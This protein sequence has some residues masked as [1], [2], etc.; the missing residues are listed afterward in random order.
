MNSSVPLQDPFSYGPMGIISMALFLAAVV[1]ALILIYKNVG[2]TPKRKKEIKQPI[3]GPI[4][5]S[6]N[7]KTKYYN[8]IVE[9]EASL[10]EGKITTR[11]AYQQMSTCTRS[12]FHEVTGVDVT[13]YTLSDI[14]DMGFPQLEYL[15]SEYYAPEFAEH[16]IGDVSASIAKTKR[17]IAEWN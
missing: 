5:I 13:T 9:I 12:F 1:I 8:V 4:V 10:N 14:H 6:V 17:V 2:R 3:Q 7:A 16:T 15:V 11:E